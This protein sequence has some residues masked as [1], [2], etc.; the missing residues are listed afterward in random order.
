MEKSANLDRIKGPIDKAKL[1]NIFYTKQA[2]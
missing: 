1:V 2:F